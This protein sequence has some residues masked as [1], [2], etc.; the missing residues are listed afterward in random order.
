LTQTITSERDCLV[1]LLLSHTQIFKEQF[2]RK[3]QNST[4][5]PTYWQML[6]SELSAIAELMVEPNGIE[7]LTSCVQGR[8]SPS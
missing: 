1:F 3:D 4:S 2:W 8:R 6:S 7:P 5:Q